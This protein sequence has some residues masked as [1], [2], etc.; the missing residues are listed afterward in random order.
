MR[1]LQGS[2]GNAVASRMAA[3]RKIDQ[4]VVEPVSK[5][6]GITGTVKA[7]EVPKN[8]KITA[9]TPFSDYPGDNVLNIGGLDAMTMLKLQYPDVVDPEMEAMAADDIVDMMGG[10]AY[11]AER[12]LVVLGQGFSQAALVHEMGHKAQNESG[13]NTATAVTSVLEYHN[14]VYSEN[15]NWAAKKTDAKPRLG[16]SNPVPKAPIPAKSWDD[17]K[18]AVQ[19]RFHHEKPMT[20]EML[21][22][23]EVTCESGRYQEEGDTKGKYGDQ[24]KANLIAEYFKEFPN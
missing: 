10:G 21:E 1:G 24:V 9:G 17:L 23:L 15:A 11:N 7:V 8:P 22:S 18:K 16:Y 19:A 20:F 2:V 12:D 3:Q 4:G 14:F 13:M 5:L 6:L